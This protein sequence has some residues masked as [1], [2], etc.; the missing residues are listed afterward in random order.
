M[1]DNEAPEKPPFLKR[2]SQRKLA[3]AREPATPS[4]PVAPNAAILPSVAEPAAG[5]TPAA[6][7]ETAAPTLPPIDSLSFDSDF[8]A[9]LQPK[10]DESLKRQALRKLFADPRFNVMDGLDVY[11]DDYNKFEPIPPDLVAQL[12]HAKFLFD[13]PKTRVNEHGHVED[14]PD[15]PPAEADIAI[16]DAAP[17]IEAAPT[18]P[19]VDNTTNDPSAEAATAKLPLPPEESQ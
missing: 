18:D 8:T 17:A 1:A 14:V 9:F 4:G 13:P 2:W 6:V 11:I 15:E 12:N 10:V 19:I 5:A 3:A 16:V 7:A